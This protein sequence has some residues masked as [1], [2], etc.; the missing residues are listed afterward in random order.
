M[1]NITPKETAIVICS[2]KNRTNVLFDYLNNIKDF[3]VYIVVRTNDY[4]ESGYDKYEFNDNIKFLKSDNLHNVTDTRWFGHQEI[5]KLGYR[6]MIMIDD[7]IRGKYIYY[8]TPETKRTTSNSYKPLKASVEETCKYII[9][10]TFGTNIGFKK[11]NKIKLNTGLT[12]CAFTFHNLDY[13]RQ[14]NITYDI[15]NPK[16][17]EDLDVVIQYLFRGLNCITIDYYGVLTNFD[18]DLSLVVNKDDGYT[19]LI[20]NTYLKYRDYVSI[21]VK[22]TGILGIRIN[23]KKIYNAFVNGLS[24]QYILEN[25]YHNKLYDLCKQYIEANKEERKL[26]DKE[27]RSL[28]INTSNNEKNRTK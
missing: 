5:M 28:I 17:L 21:T 10:P 26:I 14:Y 20:L 4:N 24:E 3:D 8:I 6:G 7:D 13:C 11:P 22:K 19:E 1:N 9:S 12:C 15:N 18:T 25:E 2:Y 16:I 23:W 27:I